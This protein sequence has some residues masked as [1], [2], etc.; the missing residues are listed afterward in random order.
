MRNML[1][2]RIILPTQQVEEAVYD[3]IRIFYTDA[4][5]DGEVTMVTDKKSTG[6]SETEREDKLS[7][8]KR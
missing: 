5:Y 4:G 6:A 3:L 8:E 7:D 2:C 1:T